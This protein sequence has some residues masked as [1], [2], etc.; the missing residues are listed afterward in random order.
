VRHAIFIALF[1]SLALLA[2]TTGCSSNDNGPAGPADGRLVIHLT[3]QPTSYENVFLDF[4]ETRV[5]RA[6]A[7]SGAGW[8]D[9]QEGALTFDLLALTNGLTENLIDSPLI[10]ATYDSLRF[11]FGEDNAV[12][13]DAFTYPIEIPT[14]L[15]DGWVL[16]YE[17]T[18]TDGGRHEATLDFDA[19]ASVDSVDFDTYVLEPVA[20][21]MGH[22]TFGWIRGLVD[23]V[24]AVPWIRAVA[25]GDTVG[26]F[27]DST[28]GVFQVSVLPPG[29]W[30]V[31]VE[32]TSAAWRDTVLT[33]VTVT[34]GEVTDL[35]TVYLEAD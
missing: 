29:T 9:V 4:V 35:E 13:V 18:I 26:T 3:D 16:P 32:P 6:G 28:T 8:T 27:A 2:A 34:A 14:A 23:P 24:E 25:G 11:V 10:P 20:R 22:G 19:R 15:Q 33:G 1:A 31:T 21:I 30:D 7:D 17:F 12:V 5:H